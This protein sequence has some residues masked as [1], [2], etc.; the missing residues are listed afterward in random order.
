MITIFITIPWFFP[1][2]KAGGPV[3]S[4]ANMVNE[5]KEGYEF[6]IYT[7]CEDLD[8]LPLD[9]SQTD[10]W[11]SY[12]NHTRVWYASRE[13]RRRYLAE[14][15]KKIQPD[16]LYMVGI[17]SWHY[18]M[19]PL[20]FT[21]G[22]IKILSVRGMLHPGALGEKAWKKKVYLQLLQWLGVLKKTAFHVT[23]AIE[24]EHVKKQLGKE[25][26]VYEAGNF[27]RKMELLKLPFKEE[28]SLRLIS[29][30]LLSPMK[31]I[32]LVL[33][34]LKECK[35]TVLYDIYGPVKEFF[36]W[37][38]CLEQIKLLPANIT[39]QY[40]KE[41]SPQDVAQKLA[42]AHVF[43]LPS[44]SENFGHAIYEALSAGL[45]VITSNH[46]PWNGLEDGR[47]GMNVIT[48]EGE[49]GKGIGYFAGMDNETFVKWSEGAVRYAEGHLDEE[50]LREGYG[51]M[52]GGSKV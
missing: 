14:E 33:A 17:Y 30:A 23:D 25:A 49:I 3:Q 29:I 4:I 46:T 48:E 13:D 51:R 45:P 18:T 42:H 43:I 41:V 38:L 11:L 44:K 47:A 35:A 40:H 28:E 22:P 15:V 32:L 12:N 20:F 37:D 10:E 27:A 16:Y 34:A 26:L 7:S 31:N 5:L 8:G 39:V 50:G 9:I 1:A 6:Y 36:Y 19:L 24:G 2:F 21:K 52:F